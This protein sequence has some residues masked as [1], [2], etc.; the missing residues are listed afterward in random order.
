MNKTFKQQVKDW[1][2]DNK[3]AIKTGFVFGVLG[4]AYGFVHG[5]T[6]TNELW[7][8]HGYTMA[9]D[10]AEGLTE[11]SGETDEDICDAN[12][13]LLHVANSNT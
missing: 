11:G 10:D 5:M 2:N 6:A 12:R 9:L 1:W 4:V 13:E 7:I 3:K 8:E